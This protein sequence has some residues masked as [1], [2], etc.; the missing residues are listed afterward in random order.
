MISIL[1]TVV[2]SALTG[3]AGLVIH[4]FGIY[5]LSP[6]L[7]LL[8]EVGFGDQF[9]L[10]SILVN[11]NYLEKSYISSSINLVFKNR[12]VIFVLKLVKDNFF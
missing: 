3:C 9:F 10:L 7:L 6:N 5:K 8:R 2:V 12:L 11:F 1:F 4:E